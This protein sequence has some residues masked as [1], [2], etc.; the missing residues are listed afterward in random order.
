MEDRDDGATPVWLTEFGWASGTPDQFCRNKGLTGQRDSLVSSFEMIL[1]NRAA[2]NIQRLFWFMWRDP[3]PGS[4]YANLCRICGTGGL[5]NYDRTPKPAYDAFIGFTAETTPPMASIT[6]GPVQG[7]LTGDATPTFSFASNEPGSTFVCHFDTRF[8]MPCASPRILSKP[9][10]NG[11]HTFYV[12]A[13]D[14]PGNESAV[15]SSTFTVDTKP[16]AVPRINDTDPNSPANYNAPRVKG[17]AEANSTVMLYKTAGCTGDPVAVG[18]AARFA[19]RGVVAQVA[20]NSTTLFR[21]TASD[22]AG[23]VSACSTARAYV[24]DST[25]PNITQTDPNSPANQNL[26]RVKGQAPAGTRVRLYKTAGCTGNPVAVG[27]AV[28]FASPGLGV[29]V[30][31]NS[32]TLFR[33]T[34]RDAAGNISPCSPARAYVEDSMPA[35]TTISSGPSGPTTDDTPTF[36][37]ASSE[38]GSTFR[39]RFDS[40]AF[41]PCSGPGASHTPSTP[42]SLGHTFEVRTIDKA[43]NADLTPAKRTFTV[44]AP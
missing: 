9:L 22:A 2:W 16:P 5:L 27:S 17:Q 24:E 18:S 21:A 20:D 42:L 36:I 7:S 33:A 1:E 43:K 8:F 38:S 14:A 44:I 6:D 23:N 30:A 3:A 28:Q 39:C 34:G 35:Q 40:E 11:P 13:I 32:T 26:L 25:I 19:S 29:T 10:S 37:F 4:E 31:N 15:A 12:K 41:A